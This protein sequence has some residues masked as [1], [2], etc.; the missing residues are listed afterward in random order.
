M[1]DEAPHIAE[2]TGKVQ[3]GLNLWI[4]VKKWKQMDGFYDTL[5]PWF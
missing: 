5:N 2:M 4:L 1:A 3:A